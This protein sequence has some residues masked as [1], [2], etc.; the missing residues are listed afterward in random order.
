MTPSLRPAVPAHPI[1]RW[2]KHW[3]LRR[4]ADAQG[5]FAMVAVDQRPP[6]QQLV[7]QARGIAPDAVG[8]DDMVAV[9]A[10]LTEGLAPGASALLVDP[11]F[12]LPAA[13]AHLRPD[14]GLVITLEDHRYADGPGGRRSQLI[15]QWSVE[16]IR[17]LGA[18]AVKLLAW[19]RP[20]ADVAVQ[21]HQQALV[22]QVGEDCRRHDI[23]F[24]FE[25]LV[26]PFAAQ[27]GGAAEYREDGSKQARRVIDSVRCFA[28]PAYGV[29]LFKLEAPLPMAELPAPGSSA[30]AGVQALFDEM[31]A[32]C[33]GT[34][35]VMLSAGASMASFEH[36]LVYA[37]RAGA[38]GFLAGRAVWL[39]ALRA[40]PDAATV[41]QALQQHSL[42]YLARL[43]EIVAAQGRPVRPQVDFSAVRQEGQVCAE[44]G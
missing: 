33:A 10:L 21:A 26:Y 29:D 39:E 22:R 27:A 25:L 34:P 12:G 44:R 8:F 9:K 16:R 4:M 17:R 6:I 5:L 41:R 38:S 36:A 7:A 23:T 19:Y 31:G 11:N 15:D 37:C 24:V 18:D 28:D 13:T 32:A 35:W 42:P 14:R 3:G 30:A 2:G 20:D 40:Y 1:A 43:R